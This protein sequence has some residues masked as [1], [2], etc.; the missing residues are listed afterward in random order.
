MIDALEE[1]LWSMWS[2]FGRGEGCT[3]VD[4]PHLLRFET[5]IPHVPYNSIMR[6][7][8]ADPDLVDDVL[9]R[10]LSRNVPI[11]WVVHPSAPAELPDLLASRGLVEAE[12]CPGMTAPLDALPEPGPLPDG[13]EIAEIGIEDAD[14][15]VDLV[16]WRYSLP[17]DAVPVVRSF[18][19]AA[20]VGDPGTTMHLFEA[21]LDGRA[22][23]KVA[24]HDG[25]GVLGVYGVATRPEARGRGLARW[26][27]LHAL[28]AAAR[29]GLDTA[30]LHSTPMA[31]SLYEGMGFEPVAD[32]RLW[33]QPDALHL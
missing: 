25:A 16:S 22:V 26:L 15:Y 7:R 28:Q 24:V 14:R 5:P 32:F 21:R 30:I 3:L 17:A 20:R 6:C 31:T 23:A 1:N 33:S 19:R 11:M 9:A 18:L 12:I 8:V 10:Y 2:T 13:I 29:P 27:T 4:E